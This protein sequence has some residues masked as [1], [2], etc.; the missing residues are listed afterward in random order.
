MKMLLVI[1]T[2]LFVV[3]AHACMDRQVRFGF[4]ASFKPV[5]YNSETGAHLGYE[6][7]LLTALE[8]VSGGRLS[9]SRQGITAWKDIWLRPAGP[10][11]D[12]AGGGITILESRTRDRAGRRAIVFTA[13]HIEFRQ[14]LLVRR[15]DAGR[16]ARYVFPG[17]DDGL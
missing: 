1:T 17:V 4:Y 14:S 8:A 5:S 11:L 9:F 10:D 13:G 6:A 16:L 12:M 7:D 2:F 3:P 15:E